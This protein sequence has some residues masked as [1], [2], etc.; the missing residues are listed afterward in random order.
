MIA[1]VLLL[2]TLGVSAGTAYYFYRE[3]A[4]TRLA[5]ERQRREQEQ[6]EARERAEE[7]GRF[8]KEVIHD[9]RTRPKEFDLERLAE[10][11]EMIPEEAALA[12]RELVADLIR[13]ALADG[14]I[15]AAERKKIESVAELLLI[16]TDELESLFRTEGREYYREAVTAALGDGVVSEAEAEE[17][18]RLRSAVGLSK[19][20]AFA[21][22]SD[23]SA[24]A[25][26][27]L[28][29]RTARTGGP[30]DQ[31]AA[32]I[33]SFRRALGGS[34]G[35]FSE[36]LRERFLDL[37]RELVAEMVQDGDVTTEEERALEWLRREALLDRAVVARDLK[38]LDQAKRL[39]A[40]RRG[41]LPT[42]ATTKLLEGGEGCHFE[43]PCRFLYETRTKQ[44]EADG[45]LVVTS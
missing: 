1:E 18:E 6:R 41:E 28:I 3:H 35:D 36:L 37:H 39:A 38:R 22:S 33:A 31:L 10:Q 17:L 23:L 42:I 9:L 11:C 26:F 15:T 34:Q 16:G 24:D 12:A 43:S 45:E 8:R 32:Y 14:V 20:E 13:R 7:R 2:T 4:R 30:G 19:A 29:R 5:R 21:L 25:Y 44:L 27:D 40:Y